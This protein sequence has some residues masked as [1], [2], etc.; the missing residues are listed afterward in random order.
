MRKLLPLVFVS[1]IALFGEGCSTTQPEFRRDVVQYQGQLFV[2]HDDSKGYETEMDKE[3]ALRQMQKLAETSE[4]EE[5]WIVYS[6]EGK[7]VVRE[8]GIQIG[9]NKVHQYPGNLLDPDGPVELEEVHIHQFDRGKFVESVRGAI[10]SATTW[11]EHEAMGENLEKIFDFGYKLKEPQIWKRYCERESNNELTYFLPPS[12][13]DIVG[14]G[15]HSKI[16]R[17]KMGK[18]LRNT[19]VTPTGIYRINYVLT[20]DTDQEF[21]RVIGVFKRFGS[22]AY[23]ETFP[24]SDD[25]EFFADPTPEDYCKWMQSHGIDV[26]FE[27]TGDFTKFLEEEALKILDEG[28]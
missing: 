19:V 27:R 4:T 28:K 3:E 16:A 10:F 18:T 26:Q 22:V 12:P 5:G 1:G 21:E 20:G 15:N 13:Q 25:R 2:N 6:R 24:S 11:N 8:T 23:D 9:N 17:E 14:H 7:T